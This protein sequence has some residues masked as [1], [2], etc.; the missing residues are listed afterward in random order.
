MEAADVLS[1]R[2]E[3]LETMNALCPLCKSGDFHAVAKANSQWPQLQRDY[4]I[5]QCE[6]CGCRYLNPRLTD[7]SLSVAYALIQEA[8]PPTSAY[9][10][11][12]GSVLTQMWRH[13]GSYQVA[14]AITDGPVLD[15][16]CNQGELLEE[17]RDKGLEAR[18]VEFSPEAV[19]WCNNLGLDV[20]EGSVEDF[21][22]QSGIFRTV[23]LSHVL[24]HLADPVRLL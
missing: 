1:E 20:V 14:D 15:L 22:I 23:V 9:S 21:E 16:G 8:L 6:E 4:T 17:L 7:E 12:R 13:Y 10:T 24:E 18:G 19:A 2:S 3:S 5:V 11:A